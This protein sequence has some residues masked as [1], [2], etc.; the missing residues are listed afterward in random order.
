MYRTNYNIP[1]PV[2]TTT[3]NSTMTT[4]DGYY[5]ERGF[6]IPFVVGGLAGG[7]LGYSVANNNF[8][9]NGGGYPNPPRPCCGPGFYPMPYGPY[10]YY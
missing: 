7:A 1:G 5:D 6:W 8:L 4:S 9:S 10:P 2:Y 3:N